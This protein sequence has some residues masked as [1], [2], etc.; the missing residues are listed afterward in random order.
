MLKKY[1]LKPYGIAIFIVI[2]GCFYFF[3]Q[4]KMMQKNAMPQEM[5]PAQVDVM[6]IEKRQI[7][8]IIEAPAR[9]SGYK[10]AQVRPQISGI[11]KKRFFN[12]GDFVKEGQ[13]L[14]Q[15]DPIIYEASYKE[16]KINLNAMQAKRNRYK[17]LLQQ[18]A[19]SQQEFDEIESSLA[20][21][22]ASY[23]AAKE[24]F[25]YTKVYAP[26]SGYIG[27]SNLTEGALVNANQN[28]P[29]AT[30]SNLDPIYA[31]IAISSAEA[32][33]IR[34]QKNIKVDL[35]INNQT[36][37]EQGN[38]KMVESFVDESTDS[39]QLRAVFSNKNQNLLPGMF[40]TAKLYLEPIESITIPQRAAVRNANGNLNLWI[41]EGNV[42]KARQVKAEKSFKDQWI[43]EEGLNEGEIIIVNGTMKLF[44][45]AKVLT[46]VQESENTKLGEEK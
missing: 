39:V 21:A 2:I 12:E 20:K 27:K 4:K 17:N 30:I 43:V 29:L 31:D 40:A 34:K 1:N 19:V 10:I 26:I 15:I 8:K 33:S 18:E 42:A 13:Q 6:I 5:P 38:L 16:A 24:N 14:Y 41:V 32:V 7:N 11:I 22:K 44:D 46:A 23:A 9:I 45:G 37:E 28:E 25:N 3:S 35:I 36:Y